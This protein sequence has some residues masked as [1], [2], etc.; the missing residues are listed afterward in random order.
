MTMRSLFTKATVLATLCAGMTLAPDAAAQ[1]H[2][3]Q[4]L[5]QMVA[6]AQHIISGEVVS[7][8]DGFDEH[9]R[10]YTEVTIRVGS[11]VKGQLG[12][13]S[14]YTFRQ[15]G[16][17]K[18]R[19]IGNGKI[20]LGVSPEGFAR[21][22]VGE[23]VVAFMN[24]TLGGLTSTVGLEQG[25]FTVQNGKVAN[26]VGNTGLFDGMTAEQLGN[27]QQNL[28]ITPGAAD[29]GQFMQVVNNLVKGAAK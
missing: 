5:P 18:P 28:L 19:S 25:K 4:P 22:Q 24:P 27:E 7:V 23:Q 8:T 17:A 16:L 21:W 29:A 13:D 11:A 10:P 9:K 3:I 12:E 26:Q 1:K 20:Y 2:I 6:Q 14:L 15:F